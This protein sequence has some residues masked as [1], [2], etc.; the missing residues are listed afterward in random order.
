MTQ[1]NRIV[2]LLEFI[3]QSISRGT[4]NQTD[5]RPPSIIHEKKLFSRKE[6]A[7]YL[8]VVPKTVT[9]WYKKGQL[10]ITYDEQNKPRYHIDDLNRCYERH[11]GYPKK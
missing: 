5:Q 9:N 3:Y 6:A 8:L 4:E 2:Q 11:W 1:I 10:P 7:A